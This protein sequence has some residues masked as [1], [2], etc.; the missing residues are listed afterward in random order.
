MTLHY[1]TTK[2]KVEFPV[3][4]EGHRFVCGNPSTGKFIS[5]LGDRPEVEISGIWSMGQLKPGKK[6][7]TGRGHLG[8]ALPRIAPEEVQLFNRLEIQRVTGNSSET[9]EKFNRR[10]DP[11]AMRVHFEVVESSEDLD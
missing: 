11:M 1:Q 10:M 7:I 9:I 2:V 8:H 5:E 4:T 3:I 6:G